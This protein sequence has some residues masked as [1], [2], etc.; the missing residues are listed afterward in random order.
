MSDAVGLSNDRVAVFWD[1]KY[2]GYAQCAWVG[3]LASRTPG[4][5]SWVNKVLR[6]VTTPD[7]TSSLFSTLDAKKYTVYR[8]ISSTLSATRGGHVAGQYRYIDVTQGL[9]WLK[10]RCAEAIANLLLSA[11]KVPYTNAGLASIRGALQG[12]VDLGVTNKLLSEGDPDDENNPPP[13]VIV[14]NVSSIS[15]SDKASRQLTGVKI[16]GVLA[17]AIDTVVNGSIIVSF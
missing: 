6:Q 2:N 12:V 5:V 1:A 3:N 15:L 7:I 14:P 16:T 13:K 9:D 10:A 11:E 17:G 8:G 4:N